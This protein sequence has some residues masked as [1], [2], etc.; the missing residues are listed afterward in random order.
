MSGTPAALEDTTTD[1]ETVVT[2]PPPRRT[3]LE[4]GLHWFYETVQPD[5]ALL[6]SAV[7]P[8]PADDGR[9]YKFNPVGVASK[10][11]IVVALAQPQ[12]DEQGDLI[13][14][15]A[16][17]EIKDLATLLDEMGHP[18]QMH[19]NG[20]P[21]ETGSLSLQRRADTSLTATR[22]RYRSGCPTHRTVFCGREGACDWYTTGTARLIEPDPSQ[23]ASA[24]EE[25]RP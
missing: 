6:Q 8:Y 11:T 1:T 4:A 10:P 22:Y 19:W 13:N 7:G 5:D 25:R 23:P 2:T 20:Y 18:V 3:V 14:P 24:H 16:P 15:I 12:R 9:T 17:G 21:S